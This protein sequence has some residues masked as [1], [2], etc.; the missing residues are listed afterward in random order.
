MRE[1]V[2]HLQPDIT[3][4]DDDGRARLP[5]RQIPAHAKVVFHRVQRIRARLIHAG[6]RRNYRAS[7]GCDE[8]PVIANPFLAARVIEH[9]NIP[10]RRI[11]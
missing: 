8:Q 11:D 9:R 3:R 2:R 4:A 6:Y 1:S 5:I 10:A 7:A